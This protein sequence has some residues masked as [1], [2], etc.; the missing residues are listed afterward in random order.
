MN[1][2]QNPHV[3]YQQQASDPLREPAA[4]ELASGGCGETYRRRPRGTG[5]LDLGWAFG[6][7]SVLQG[8][9]KQRR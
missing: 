2:E 1:A 5:H 8:R 6:F 3:K 9:R 7:E 4:D